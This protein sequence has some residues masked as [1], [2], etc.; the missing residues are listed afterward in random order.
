MIGGKQVL[1]RAIGISLVIGFLFTGCGQADQAATDTGI[2]EG[3][4]Q[5][6]SEEKTENSEQPENREQV[7]AEEQADAEEYAEVEDQTEDKD[8]ATTVIM[9]FRSVSGS[10]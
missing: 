2:E 7:A 6:A 4:E 3:D 10:Y 5:S 9:T 1:K 8:M